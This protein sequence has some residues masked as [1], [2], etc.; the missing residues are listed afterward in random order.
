VKLEGRATMARKWERLRKW[1]SGLL[2]K[3]KEESGNR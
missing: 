3:R 2:E 1:Q